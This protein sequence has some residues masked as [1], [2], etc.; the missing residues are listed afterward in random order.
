MKGDFII[1]SDSIDF[2][3]LVVRVLLLT[4]YRIRGK[5]LNYGRKKLDEH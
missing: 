1:A 3:I 2:V 5:C 4:G